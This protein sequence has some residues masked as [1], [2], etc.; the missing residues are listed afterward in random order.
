MRILSAALL[1]LALLSLAAC[2]RPWVNPNIPDSKQADYQ[3]DKDSTDCGI[4]ASEKYPLSKNQQLP[5]Y[6]QCLQDR[7]WI[8]REPGDGIPLNR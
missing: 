5:L 6:E 8:K 3:F 7:G 4:L 1:I 2:S